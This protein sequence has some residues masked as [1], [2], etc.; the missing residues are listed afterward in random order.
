MA[1]YGREPVSVR[2][3]VL[4]QGESGIHHKDDVLAHEVP[5]ALVY[6]GISHTVMMCSPLDLE[7]FALGFSL[8][9]GII[10]SPKELYDLKVTHEQLGITIT[11]SISNR[12][13]WRLAKRRRTLAGRTGCGICGTEQLEQVVKAVAPLQNSQTFPVQQ[14]PSV[15]SKLNQRELQPLRAETGA[16]HGAFWLDNQGKV[17]AVR[18]D[19]GRHVAL[20]KIIGFRAR[21]RQQEGVILV[22]SRASFEMVQKAAAVGIEVLMAMSAATTMAVDLAKQ[23][24][25]SLAGFCRADQMVIYTGEQRFLQA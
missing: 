9:E 11:L 8:A 16:V 10:E 25:L 13:H 23:Y 3:V 15:L 22:T 21:Q 17:L 14:L 1:L 6:N 20:D 2:S 12:A 4:V 24:N 18:E 5:V 7:D 19:I